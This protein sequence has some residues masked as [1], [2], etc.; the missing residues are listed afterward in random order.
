MDDNDNHEYWRALWSIFIAN[1]HVD[2]VKDCVLEGHLK[3]DSTDHISD[4]VMLEKYDMLR[5]IWDIG[6]HRSVIGTLMDLYWH[7]YPFKSK[8]IADALRIPVRE[9]HML[10]AKR[11]FD[12]GYVNSWWRYWI[13]EYKIFHKIPIKTIKKWVETD[14]NPIHNVRNYIEEQFGI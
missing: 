4:I 5:A 9:L 6:A 1:N 14:D 13:V 2:I 7:D 3:W 10:I 12:S 11:V 8:V